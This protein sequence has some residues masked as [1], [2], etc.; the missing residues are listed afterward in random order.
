MKKHTTKKERTVIDSKDLSEWLVHIDINAEWLCGCGP[1]D[2]AILRAVRGNGN[3]TCLG[4]SVKV[5]AICTGKKAAMEGGK[6]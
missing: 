2:R 6:A 1:V 3:A 4:G 5:V